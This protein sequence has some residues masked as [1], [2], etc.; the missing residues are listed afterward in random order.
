MIMIRALN[1]TDHDS[2]INI[3]NEN[4]RTVYSGYV[5][6]ALLSDEGCRIRA[7]EMKNDFTSQRF[8]EYIWEENGCVAAL[9]SLG[10]TED[11]DKAGAYELWRIYIA[12]EMQGKGIGGKLLNFAEEKAKQKG[13]TE[14]LIWAFQE[15]TRAISFYQKHGFQIDKTEFLEEPYH[16]YCVRLT[17]EI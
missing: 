17:K 12:P 2:T 14:M 11:T 15:N 10:K 6:S 13:Y 3:V 5:N 9:L 4:W 16:T 8:E 1:E 7:S